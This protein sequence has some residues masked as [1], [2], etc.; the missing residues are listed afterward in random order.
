MKPIIKGLLL[1]LLFSSATLAQ[2]SPTVKVEVLSKTSTSWDGS[3]F[4]YPKGQPEI[5]I[6][7]ITL[8]PG[9]KLPMHKHPNPLGGI[10]LKGEIVVTRE[11]GTTHTVK[12][13][14]AIVELVNT[15]HYGKNDTDQ[16]TVL[17]AFYI[18]EVGVPLSVNKDN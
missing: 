1:A 7:K 17:L 8:P 15:W 14:E 6:S 9:F 12:E 4:E 2:E 10:V 3:A 5:T 16:P 18:G 11:D 13:G